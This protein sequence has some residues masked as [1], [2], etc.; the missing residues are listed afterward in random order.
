VGA[1]ANSFEDIGLGIEVASQLRELQEQASKTQSPAVEGEET[2]GGAVEEQEEGG[3]DSDDEAG[4]GEEG[5]M[6]KVGAERATEKQRAS[7]GE[8]A[9]QGGEVI[10]AREGSQGKTKV[11]QARSRRG[12]KFSLWL[13]QKKEPD[14]GA[15]SGGER[16]RSGTIMRQ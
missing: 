6:Q 2:D 15:K 3:R 16:V 5:L 14:I 9:Q 7:Q 10:G 13:D 4:G 1:G 11:A 8:G 12:M